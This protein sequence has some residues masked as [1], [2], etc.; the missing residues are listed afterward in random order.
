MCL[1]CAQYF[2]LAA[3]STNIYGWGGNDYLATGV[4]LGSAAQVQQSVAL[5][6][7]GCGNAQ[8]VYVALASCFA[9][10]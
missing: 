5:L 1:A 8:A 6:V 9:F 3:S 4:G 10:V 2:S 7:C